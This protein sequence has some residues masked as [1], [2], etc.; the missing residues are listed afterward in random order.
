MSLFQQKRILLHIKFS[1]KLS[2][3]RFPW[4]S[5][6]IG[7]LGSDS[8]LKIRF[9]F[10]LH[11][12]NKKKGPTKCLIVFT[13]HLCYCIDDLKITLFATK[14]LG[15]RCNK[16]SRKIISSYYYDRIK[17]QKM[18]CYR[19][20]GTS[21]CGVKA[22]IFFGL[23]FFRGGQ[24]RARLGNGDCSSSVWLPSDLEEQNSY[25]Q[26]LH[27]VTIAGRKGNTPSI[28]H[29]QVLGLRPPFAM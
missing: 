19:E 21:L 26:S 9:H 2:I 7:E 15:L 14:K 3:S 1:G 17:G 25:K 20:T 23:L 16:V 8:S 11:Y 4:K 13:I 6:F 5:I 10:I 29:S 22:L 24:S 27:C 18:C 12:A 28:L